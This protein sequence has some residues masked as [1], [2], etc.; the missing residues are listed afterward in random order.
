M[1]YGVSITKAKTST[2]L[3]IACSSLT[4]PSDPARLTKRS[5][6]GAEGNGGYFVIQNQV[7]GFTGRMVESRLKRGLINIRDESEL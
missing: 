5:D 4:D 1:V 7:L 6:Q 3:D 2:G